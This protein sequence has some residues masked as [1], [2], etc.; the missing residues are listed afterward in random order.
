MSAHRVSC[1]RCGMEF[2][3]E[4]E[5]MPCPNCEGTGI[6][7]EKPCECCDG[8]G[9]INLDSGIFLCEECKGIQEP[10]IEEDA[11]MWAALCGGE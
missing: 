9:I 1:D 2:C 3:Y 8:Y 7:E 4:E 10:A 11:A 5:L 6:S